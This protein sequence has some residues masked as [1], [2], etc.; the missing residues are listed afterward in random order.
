MLTILC[1]YANGQIEKE[2]K[3]PDEQIIVNK[4]YDE[5]GN[6]I[7]FDSSYMHQ[8]SSD[9]T[10]DLS[11]K[12]FFAGNMF[13]DLE[14]LTENFMSDSASHYFDFPDPFLGSP[15]GGKDPQE[16]FKQSFPDSLFMKDFNFEMNSPEISHGFVLLNIKELKKQMKKQFKGFDFILSSLTSFHRQKI[17]LSIN[18]ILQGI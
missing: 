10:L 16:R 7:T 13:P 4:E 17:L 12:D 11:G 1:F 14:K 15:F 2:F 8:C 3:K 6:Q 18:R 5:D 9:T